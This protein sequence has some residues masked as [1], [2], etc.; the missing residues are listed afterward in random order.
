MMYR[1][2]KGAVDTWYGTIENKN[3]WKVTQTK[4]INKSELQGMIKKTA[5]N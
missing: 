1:V 4:G 5:N 3:G 2:Q